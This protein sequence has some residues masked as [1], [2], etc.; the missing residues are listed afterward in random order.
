MLVAI[1][2]T[3]IVVLIGLYSKARWNNYMLSADFTRVMGA[4]NR[5]YDQLKRNYDKSEEG[6]VEIVES[7]ENML[8]DLNETISSLETSRDIHL[9]DLLDKERLIEH[10]AVH[11]HGIVED[12]VELIMA[13][14]RPVHPD[15][16]PE[17]VPADG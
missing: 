10:H 8:L 14:L 7:Y 13:R 4:F 17:G 11:C 1:L 2:I 15:E 3:V 12:S 5:E 6:I 16:E 9:M